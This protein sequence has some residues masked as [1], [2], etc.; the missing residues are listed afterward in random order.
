MLRDTEFL[1]GLCEGKQV[2]LRYSHSSPRRDGT[3]SKRIL[4]YVFVEDGGKP[5][6]VNAEIC[7]QGFTY[8][9]SKYPHDRREEFRGYVEKAREAK[10]GLWG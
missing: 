1:R 6:D 5:I 2:R 4:A 3:S 8:W 7:K 10:R 9:Y